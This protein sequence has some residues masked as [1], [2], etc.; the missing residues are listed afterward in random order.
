M[1]A[2]IT[3][4]EHTRNFCRLELDGM[5]IHLRREEPGGRYRKPRIYTSGAA[6][7]PS[8]DHPPYGSTR[9]DGSESDKAWRRYNREEIKLQRALAA[10][11]LEALKAHGL[12][13]Y[14]VRVGTVETKFSRYAGCSCS[15]S[16]GLIL[17]ADAHAKGEL[18]EYDTRISDIWVEADE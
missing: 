1:N 12:A 9:G 4:T 2:T 5:K 10:R 14:G 6:I 13:T 8:F 3:I 16:P 7:T 18:F 17:Q 11:A 15:C